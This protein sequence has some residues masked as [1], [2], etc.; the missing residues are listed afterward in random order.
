MMKGPPRI[1]HEHTHT[2]MNM[3]LRTN[4]TTEDGVQR[5]KMFF[6][7]IYGKVLRCEKESKGVL[8]VYIG[9]NIWI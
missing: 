7:C 1:S 2:H 9:E 6:V 4:K 8:V 3:C 5:N